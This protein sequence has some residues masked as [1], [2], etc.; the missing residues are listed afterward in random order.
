MTAHDLRTTI[1]NMARALR[2]L[3][4]SIEAGELSASAPTVHRLEGAAVA[5]EVVL[6]D[7]R[8]ALDSLLANEAPVADVADALLADLGLSTDTYEGPR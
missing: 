4:T 5:L 2:V 8:P 6:D 7:G 3:V 1:E